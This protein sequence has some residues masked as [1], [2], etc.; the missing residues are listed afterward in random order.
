MKK[1][2]SRKILLAVVLVLALL[3]AAAS[4]VITGWINREEEER[5]YE[6]LSEET[7]R[8]AGEIRTEIRGD[9][10]NLRMLAAVIAA[11]DTDLTSPEVRSLLGAYSTL[12]MISRVELLLPDDTVVTKSGQSDASGVRSFSEEAAKGVHVSR[13]ETDPDNGGKYILRSYVPVEKDGETVAMLYG[14]IE[15]GTLPGEMAA[16][17][18]GGE[19][20][21][22]IIE[23][24]TG[25]FLVDTWHNEAGGNI[26]ALGERKMAPG[27]NH[28]QLKAG[29]TEGKTGYVVFVSDTTGEYLYF[30][31][32]PVGINDWQL[33]L[34]VPEKVVFENAERIR[35]GMNLYLVFETVCFVI[36]VLWI[37][38]YMRM[39][40]MFQWLWRELHVSLRRNQYPCG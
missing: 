31:Y 33:A 26:W 8:L 21:V 23:G 28:E 9:T 39:K 12:G 40:K 34:S 32:E 20:A 10:E 27:Y 36:G 2:M 38:R 17:P 7:E 25:D 18:Y 14:V 22:Y 6:L 19:A 24:Q 11:E 30:Y 37:F 29:M 35:L 1:R 15:P 13:R 5:S 4:F 16:E 3:I